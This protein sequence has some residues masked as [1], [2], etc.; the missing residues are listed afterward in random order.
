MRWRNQRTR[1]KSYPEPPYSPPGEILR[2]CC[3]C[4]AHF[5][6]EGENSLCYRCKDILEAEKNNSY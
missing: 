2:C 4:G 5:M 1:P 6:D 3:R